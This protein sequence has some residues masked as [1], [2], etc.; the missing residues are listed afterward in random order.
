MKAALVHD[1]DHP[2]AYRE[3]DAP[4]PEAGQVVVSVSAAA[5]SNLVKAQAAGKHYSS[6]PQAWFVPGVDGVGRLEGG[7]RVYFAFPR[8]PFGAMAEKSVVLPALCA[9]VPDDVDDVTAAAA[10]NPGMSSWAALTERAGFEAGE[11]VL[12]NGATGVS[13][14]LAVQIAKHLG[15]RRVI[16]TGR[17]DSSRDALLSLG[18]DAFV[19]LEGPREALVA[20][21]EG[22]LSRGGV[23]VVLDYLWGGSAEAFIEAVAATHGGG[24]R[25]IRFVQIGSMSGATIALPG[26]ALRSSG[27][28]LVGSGLGS[29]SKEQLVRAVE[30]M[31]AALVP[32]KMQVD[33][34]PVPLRDVASAWNRPT[35]KRVVFTM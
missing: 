20:S 26:A 12:I 10:G 5:L 30:Q 31:L 27:L 35:T 34:E 18:A 1:F 19:P 9:A 11:S 14:R 22:E 6:P 23:D 25:R 24:E 33:V 16:A 21:F 3:F 28:E 2:P 15:A 29:V 4:A 13:G 7:K 32:A 8:P 17:N